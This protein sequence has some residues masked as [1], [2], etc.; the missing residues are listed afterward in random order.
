[1]NSTITN[2]KKDQ[3]IQIKV[4]PELKQALEQLATEQNIATSR[5]L[6]IA[7]AKQYPELVDLVLKH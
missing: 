1:M 3:L 7:V 6:L 4:T 5:L 2:M